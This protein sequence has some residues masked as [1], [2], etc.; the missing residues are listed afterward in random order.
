MQGIL[1]YFSTLFHT[2]NSIIKS[3][4]KK[5][6][7][8]KV[9]FFY[10]LV[11]FCKNHVRWK[12]NAVFGPEKTALDRIPR[13]RRTALKE[14]CLYLGQSLE[15]SESC[16]C[17]RQFCPMSTGCGI[18]FGN[19]TNFKILTEPL[20]VQKQTIPHTQPLVLNDFIMTNHFLF[21]NSM[22]TEVENLGEYQYVHWKIV[23]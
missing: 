18:H 17:Q 3:F 9:F 11:S 22:K 7:K 13:Y 21:S 2:R 23:I 5:N 8:T 20:L 10:I 4:E 14:E 16:L 6:K 12:F 15:N 1:I 19:P